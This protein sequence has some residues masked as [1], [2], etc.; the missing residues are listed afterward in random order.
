[1]DSL[2]A[3]QDHLLDESVPEDE[4]VTHFI[5]ISLGNHGYGP[6]TDARVVHRWE[7]IKEAASG[8]DLPIF[9]MY[10]NLPDFYPDQHDSRLN[11]AAALT[12][13]NSAVPLLLQNGI[14]RFLFASSHSYRVQGV[15]A[16][17]DM[18]KADSILL[19]ALSTERTELC[20]VG[21]EHTRVEK[22]RRIA[23]LDVTQRYLDVCIMEGDRNCSRCEKCMRT[24]LALELDGTIDAFKERFDLDVYRE[25]RD[26]FI[27]RVWAETEEDY[28][29]ELQEFMKAK[30]VTPP[31]K[32]RLMAHALQTWRLIPEDLRRKI[33]GMK[34]RE[35]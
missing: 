3:I 35:G 13:R 31:P 22:T 25:H 1:V 32:A 9:R 16:T 14:R 24:L 12:L 17:D 4:R 15:F 28:H 6:D 33:R 29:L 8:F 5:F 26:Q 21:C 20:S 19:P 11:W 30:G 18:T 34:E 23:P 7:R 10:S 2:S 27:A